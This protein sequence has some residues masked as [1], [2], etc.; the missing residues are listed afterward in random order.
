M[1]ERDRSDDSGIDGIGLHGGSLLLDTND[2][3]L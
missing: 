2:N 3:G 1:C